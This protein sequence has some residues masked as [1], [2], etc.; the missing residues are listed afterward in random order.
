[1]PVADLRHGPIR[2]SWPV[3]V[4][5]V[6]GALQ[7]TDASPMAPGTLEVEVSGQKSRVMVRGRARLRVSLPCAV[8]LDPVPVDLEPEV[9]LVLSPAPDLAAPAPRSR[10]KRDRRSAN[11]PPSESTRGRGEGG[12]WASD[13]TLDDDRAA[14]DSYDGERVVL[15]HFLREFLLLELPM[16][17]RRSDLPL[18]EDAAIRPPSRSEG[19]R[20]PADLD[21]RLLP[22]AAIAS[23]L[24]NTKE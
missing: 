4:D 2:V 19:A 8:S 18:A 24:R 21:P 3:P 23:R 7:G 16:I 10:S 15:D 13:P 20:A 9:F 5:W 17:V 12:S 22:L 11:R 1:M 14:E 6:R